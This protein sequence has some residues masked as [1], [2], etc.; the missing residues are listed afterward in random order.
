MRKRNYVCFLGVCVCVCVCDFQ[1]YV[2]VYHNKT[3]N[4]CH[5]V[6]AVCVCV[7]YVSKS[8]LLSSLYL[9]SR[10]IGLHLEFHSEGKEAN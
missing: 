4:M 3:D 7:F 8:I 2:V 6:V 10:S 5:H 1:K 9:I